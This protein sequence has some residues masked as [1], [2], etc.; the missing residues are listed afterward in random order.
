MQ[1]VIYYNLKENYDKLK[2]H[3]IKYRWIIKKGNK[4]VRRKKSVL[5]I[6]KYKNLSLFIA[7]MVV[8]IESPKYKFTKKLLKPRNDKLAK[9]QDIK[10]I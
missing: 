3:I 8:N 7:D 5:T 1:K 6:K 10:W 4:E 2:M 9:S